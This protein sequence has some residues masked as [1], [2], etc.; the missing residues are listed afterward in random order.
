MSHY[1]SIYFHGYLLSRNCHISDATTMQLL[2]EISESLH[3]NMDFM[4]VKDDDSQVAQLISR[5]VCMVNSDY[6]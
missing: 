5:F 4:N 6:I 2:F 3:D 1:L